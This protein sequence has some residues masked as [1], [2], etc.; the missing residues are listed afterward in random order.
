MTPTNEVASQGTVLTLL[1]ADGNWM[2][3]KDVCDSLGVD[4]RD[5]AARFLRKLWKY[6]FLIRRRRD[7]SVELEYKIKD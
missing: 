1:E 2:T 5:K 7:K 6:D 4:C 3:S